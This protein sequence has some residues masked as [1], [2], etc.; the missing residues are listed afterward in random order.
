MLSILIPT[1]NYNVTSLVAELHSQAEKCSAK[2]EIIV[3]EDGSKLHLEENQH[4]TKLPLCKYVVLSENIGRSAI[5]N[6]LASE[7]KFEHLLFLDCD[8]EIQNS[9]FVEKYLNYCKIEAIIVGGTAYDSLNENPQYSLRTKYGK[10]REAKT[11]EERTKEGIYS[12]FSTFNFLI[13][14]NLFNQIQFNEDIH[15]YGHEDTLFGHQISELKLAIIHIDNPLIHKGLDD[16]LTFIKK[17]EEATRNLYLLY[18]SNQY[19]YLANQSK[20]LNTYIKLN[21]MRLVSA[22]AELFILSKKLILQ[23]LTSKI[24]SLRLF[25]VYKLLY[26]CNFAN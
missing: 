16:N 12:H 25:D 21:E 1:Y 13:S 4:I 2:I 22:F 14:K 19:P 26:L 15:G 8:G 11:A 3:M 20:L 18:K 5:R 23:N 7:A 24:P 10:I 17:T 6:R 9:D